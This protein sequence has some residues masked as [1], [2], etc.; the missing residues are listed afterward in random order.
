MCHTIGPA[1]YQLSEFFI[2]TPFIDA[3]L[4]TTDYDA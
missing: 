1:L 3:A 2:P 4:K